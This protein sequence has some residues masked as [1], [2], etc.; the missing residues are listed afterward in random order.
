M[1]KPRVR[2]IITPSFSLTGTGA[3]KIFTVPPIPRMVNWR[4][5][6]GQ[7]AVESGTQ[8]SSGLMF[9]S[10][11]DNGALIEWT[12]SGVSKSLMAK[13]LTFTIL[14]SG[15]GLGPWINTSTGT[16]VCHLVLLVEESDLD[17]G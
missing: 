9:F 15:L 12:E 14:T 2:V 17:I 7:Y 5:M 1:A 16:V 10:G 3:K 13:E 6:G 11:G 4:L 8:T